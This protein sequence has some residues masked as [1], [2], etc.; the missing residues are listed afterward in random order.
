MY[1]ASHD[2]HPSKSSR[3]TRKNTQP[4]RL[5]FNRY[6]VPCCC[7]WWSPVAAV[8]LGG[9]RCA[10]RLGGTT[11]GAPC[12]GGVGRRRPRP[13]GISSRSTTTSRPLITHC[14]ASSRLNS[15]VLHTQGDDIHTVISYRLHSNVA[16]TTRR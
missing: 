2:N 7:W 5:V 3:D 8:P 1:N 4:M 13:K 11:A 6:D 15:F 14:S 12:C 16:Q 9:G 10:A